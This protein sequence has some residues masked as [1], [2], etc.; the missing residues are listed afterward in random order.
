M[1]KMCHAAESEE[2]NMDG[3][4]DVPTCSDSGWENSVHG[5]KSSVVKGEMGRLSMQ[6]SPCATPYGTPRF[7]R[8]SSFSSF[9]SCFSKFGKFFVHY[10]LIA[11]ILP[12]IYL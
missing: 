12:L 8:E 6:A 5:N 2:G 7:S 10:S 4:H 9:V 11:E 1:S 3:I